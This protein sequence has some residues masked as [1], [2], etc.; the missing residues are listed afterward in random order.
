MLGMSASQK[1]GLT[2]L[3]IGI[4]RKLYFGEDNCPFYRATIFS[5]YSPHNSPREDVKLPTLQLAN[6]KPSPDK[7][8]QPGPYW[9][10]M[11]EVSESALKPV[12]QETIVAE[13]IQGLVNTELYITSL[14][15]LFYYT[16]FNSLRPDDEIVS[17]YH[18]RFHHGYPTPTLSRDAALDKLLPHLEK[19]DILSRGRF[20]S[21]KYEVGNQDHSF[22]LGVEAVDKIVNGGVELTL[23]YPD[24]VNGRA[25]TERRLG[26]S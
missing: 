12:N 11:L 5:N 1:Q 8:S 15:S 26:R 4:L 22:M 18:R 23:N 20:G 17:I 9:S 16:D 19:Q 25:N 14:F 6:G 24:F 21:W 2:S 7:Q 10:I 3:L 13:S